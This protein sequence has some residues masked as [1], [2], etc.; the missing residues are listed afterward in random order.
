VITEAKGK[1]KVDEDYMDHHINVSAW[2]FFI[3]WKPRLHVSWFDG[4]QEK[5]KMFTL[6]QTCARATEAEQRGLLFA[7]KWIEEGK[8][9]LDFDTVG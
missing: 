1:I 4:Y 2:Y 3:G 6:Q 8:P 5:N 7:K 9:M